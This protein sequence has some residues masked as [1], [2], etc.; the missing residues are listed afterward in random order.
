DP[1][2]RH[3]D[4]PD[5]GDRRLPGPRP[6]RHGR[7]RAPHRR[8]LPG[9]HARPAGP[10]RPARPRGRGDRRPADGRPP[11]GRG[12][13]DRPGAGARRR[14][15]R[16][17]RHPPLRPRRRPDGR[18]ARRLRARRL[19]PPLLLVR[20]AHAAAGGH[21]GLRAR[22]RRGVLPGGGERGAADAPPRA[23]GRH[24]RPPH[25]RG[26]LQGVRPRPAGRRFGGPGRDR[27]PVDQGHADVM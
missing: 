7:R 6:G 8:R 15:G 10:P 11:H 22:G 20:R 17:A 16:P 24:E 23:A 26:V 3:P 12:H 27:R 25:D 5:G 14:A 21:R 4:P 18:G 1:A 19:G 13:G 9:P 2:H